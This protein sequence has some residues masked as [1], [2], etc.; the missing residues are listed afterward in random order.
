MFRHNALAG[1]VVL[2]LPAISMAGTAGTTDLR[3]KTRPDS[4]AV[5]RAATSA[6]SVRMASLAVNQSPRPIARPATR[7]EAA[8]VVASLSDTADENARFHAWIRAFRPRAEAQGIRP[9][10]LD[11]A[12]RNVQF[13][14][15]VIRLDSSQAEFSKPIWE[16]LDGAVSDSRI[17]NGKAALAAQSRTLAGVE[18]RYGVDKEVVLAIWG[19][20]TNYGG[21]RGRNSVIDSLATLAFEGR[22]SSFFEGELIAALQ[23]LQAGDTVPASMKGSWAGAMGHTQFMPTSFLEYAVDYTGDGRR[24]IWGEDPADALASTAAYLKRHGWTKGQPWGVEVKLPRGFDYTQADRKVKKTP[25]EWARLGVAGYNGRSIPNY[26]AASIL[27]PAGGGGA[28]FMIFDNFAVIERYNSADAYVIGVGHLSDRIKG[29]PAIQHGWPTGDRTLSLSERKEMQALLT[30]RGFDT[31][32]I[33]GR[34]GPKTVSAVRA[35]QQA[36]GM[37]PD[38]FPSMAVLQRLR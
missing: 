28:A 3:P 33:D 11:S 36:A 30:A 27:L 34:I 18:S 29:G 16:Y 23:I 25:S 24:D 22:R 19:M 1:A 37:V 5:G 10:T 7:P 15:N 14:P 38:G 21:Y 26:S 9:A 20:E 12:F 4:I 8:N 17:T 35:Y 32:G 31:L 13:D 2:F 6:P